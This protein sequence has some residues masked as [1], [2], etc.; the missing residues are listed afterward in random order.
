MAVSLFE[1]VEAWRRVLRAAPPSGA[2]HEVEVE[3]I[4]VRDRMLVVMEA[5]GL[6]ESVVFD[7][8]WGRPGTASARREIVV[9]TFLAV[10][11]LCRI[12]A[13]QVYQ[14]LT[15]QGCPQGPIH[16]RLGAEGDAAGWRERI[17]E[18]M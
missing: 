6:R 18:I 2:A 10:L 11:E 3:T 14:G 1:L 5:L 17:A 13:V 9:A 16:L 4:T 7:E 15:P 8:L 12:A